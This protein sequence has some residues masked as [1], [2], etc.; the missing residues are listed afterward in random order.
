MTN[1]SAGHLHLYWC[2]TLDHAE[3]WF[4][5]ERTKRG[6]RRF[7]M[8]AEGYSP[9]DQIDVRSVM[10]LPTELQNGTP[11][12]W[13]SD[14]LLQACSGTVHY[15]VEHRGPRFVIF[16]GGVFYEGGCQAAIDQLEARCRA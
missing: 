9:D 5:V 13:A 15:H 2:A 3:D 6:A 1:S 11:I 14:E 10:L 8:E 16:D 4:V 12:G 7:F